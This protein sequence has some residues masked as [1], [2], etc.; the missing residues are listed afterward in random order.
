[1]TVIQRSSYVSAS[2]CDA[3]VAALPAFTTSLEG[4][5]RGDEGGDKLSVYQ[6]IKRKYFTEEL[7]TAW[8]NSMPAEVVNN[9]LISSFLKIPANTGILHPTTLG[10]AV[11]RP[12][13]CF[14]SVALT[15]GQNLKINGTKYEV[16][17][18]DA[19]I[20]DASDTYATDTISTD[21]LWSVNMVPTWK[22]STYAG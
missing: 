16:N 1:M 6:H 15:D 5:C 22:K 14:L 9:Y 19:L 3:M 8:A 17:K 13:G 10:N 18:G 11:D 4:H 20:F 7:K 12:I 21:A 2:N